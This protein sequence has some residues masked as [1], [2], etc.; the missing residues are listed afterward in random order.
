MG[1]TETYT[2]GQKA[3]AFDF[4]GSSHVT[5]ANEGNFD[6]EH[7]QAFSI[8]FWINASDQPMLE[9]LVSKTTSTTAIGWKIFNPPKDLARFRLS[10]GITQFTVTSVTIVADDTF[11]YVVCTYD[12]SSNRSGM[13]VYVDGILESTGAAA[14]ISGTLLNNESVVIGAESDGGRPITGQIDD[15]RIFDF[16]LTSGQV[17]SLFGS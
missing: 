11:H 2:P 8:S 17:T 15:P 4:D 7:N 12:G 9:F 16:E 3:F 1:G 13:K 10:D 6:F 14:T 5:L